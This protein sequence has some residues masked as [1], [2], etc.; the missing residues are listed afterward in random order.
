[1]LTKSI[2]LLAATAL[3]LGLIQS[4]SAADL[5]VKAPPPMVAAPFISW[6]GFYLGGHVGSGWGTTEA[7]LDSLTVAGVPALLGTGSF[8]LASAGRNG[9]IGGV[10]AGYNWQ[11]APY[12][13]VG[14]EGD[15][16]WS[17]IKGTA[18]CGPSFGGGGVIFCHAK[19]NWIGDITGRIGVTVDH[20]LLYLKGGWAWQDTD[21]TVSSVSFG[22]GRSSFGGDRQQH[23]RW[24]SAGSRRGVPIHAALVG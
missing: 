14:V 11:V 7:S 22:G 3:G 21:Y 24:R 20:A 10:Q 5:P 23:S 18:P 2:G 9:F 4:A 19:D 12:L 1:M 13:V 6:T 16:S 15:F 17:D 8:P